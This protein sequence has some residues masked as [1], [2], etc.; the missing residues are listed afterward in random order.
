MGNNNEKNIQVGDCV[1]DSQ[2]K[3]FTVTKVNTVFEI[4]DTTGQIISLSSKDG[5]TKMMTED[6]IQFAYETITEIL[7]F[8]KKTITLQKDKKEKG[9]IYGSSL[10]ILIACAFDAMGRIGLDKDNQN[11]DGNRKRFE[12]I[13]NKYIKD[14]YGFA[15]NEFVDVFYVIYRCGLVHSGSI[16]YNHILSIDSNINNVLVHDSGTTMI[17]VPA[18]IDMAEIVFKQLCN[19]YQIHYSVFKFVNNAETGNTQTIK[20]EII[21]S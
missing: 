17:N 9:D 16:V 11:S 18:L 19:E 21:K 2:H 8:T 7:D 15:N 13:Q 10:T 20:N 3:R 6:D 12:F 14:K 4:K 1:M 5:Y